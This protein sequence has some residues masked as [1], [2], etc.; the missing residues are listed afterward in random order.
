MTSPTD[1]YTGN[2]RIALFAGA[3]VASDLNR[4]FE[5]SGVD[6][7]SP[8]PSM[9]LPDHLA[10]YKN[11]WKIGALYFMREPMEIRILNESFRPYAENLER[12]LGL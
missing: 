5:S 10:F 4:A 8:A 11:G 7:H 6:S 12:V 2:E 1:D 9:P 3:E